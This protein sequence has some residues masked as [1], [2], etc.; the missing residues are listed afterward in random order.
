M[1]RA[2]Q[3]LPW[4]ADGVDQGEGET[5]DTLLYI[6]ARNIEDL[7]NVIA[8]P[9]LQALDETD[10]LAVRAM[11]RL[12]R[13]GLLSELL[14]HPSMQPG[15]SD[16]H[17]V[18][19]IA[20]ATLADTGEI[21]RLLSPG[22]T[23]I[24]TAE[25]PTSQTPDLKASIV[26]VGDQGQEWTAEGIRSA[27]DF[28][29]ST[30]GQPLPTSHVVLLLHDGA[31]FPYANGVNYGFAITYRP[32]YEQAQETYE[33]QV[34]RSGLAHEIAHYYWRGNLS[35]VDEGLADLTERLYGEATGG[36][37]VAWQVVRRGCEAHD[38]QMLTEWDPHQGSPQFRCTY[39]LGR[40]LFD[41]LLNN[42]PSED[43]TVKLR[44]LYDLSLEKQANGS[45]IG[46]QSIRQIFPSRAAIVEKHWSGEVNAPA[47]RT[48][49]SDLLSHDL[50]RWNQAPT[51][52][53]S[54]FVSLRATLLSDSNLSQTNQ[55]ARDSEGY[56]NF[57]L[58][59]KN[60]YVGTILP[61]LR[62]GWNW[63]LSESSR[64]AESHEYFIYPDGFR[65]AFRFPPILDN[66]TEFYV[67]VR[68]FRD[69]KMVPYVGT[70]ADVLG[71]A[72]IE[73]KQ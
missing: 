20:S 60:G 50:I 61:T 66:P 11:Y 58:Y 65:V 29:E 64:H 9:F 49:V 40:R 67:V 38:L 68:G 1:A 62:P 25:L 26:R 17:L 42:L 44:D 54:G 16:S 51:V 72:K 2:V 12:S 3:A 27:V 45:G 52:S 36:W 21:D 47:N 19:I 59:D 37:P 30:M 33:G 10:K 32:K 15:V 14:R 73:M 71:F 22:Y 34:F 8:M 57:T 63:N 41:E 43:V 48:A 35:W 55:Q 6:A 13:N 5:I 31:V 46:I 56:P 24:E 7:K 18:L 28:I 53:R 4:V 70:E 39:Y 69:S 23:T